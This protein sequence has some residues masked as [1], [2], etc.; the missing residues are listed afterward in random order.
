[1]NPPSEG[2]TFLFYSIPPSLQS[3]VVGLPGAA[4]SQLE[5]ELGFA[6]TRSGVILAWATGDP[7]AIDFNYRFGSFDRRDCC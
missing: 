6:A 5:T 1:M 7:F 4:F 2:V 3:L